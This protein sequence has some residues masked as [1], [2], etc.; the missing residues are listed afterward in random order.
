MILN[1]KKRTI[2]LHLRRFLLLFVLTVI[3]ILIFYIDSFKESVYVIKRTYFIV[4]LVSLYWLYFFIGFIR[5]YHFFLY[6]DNGSKLVFRYYSLRPFNKKQSAVEID[7]NT[8]ADFKIENIFFGFITRLYL[9]QKMPNGIIAKYPPINI[10]LLKN[11]EINQLSESLN[12]Y[13]R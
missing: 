2:N 13:K 10:T 12:L 9:F 1:I 8:F 4:G 5:N 11:K 3:I 7:K 6:S